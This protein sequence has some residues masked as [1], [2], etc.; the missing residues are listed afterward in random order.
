MS[1]DKP[2]AIAP[3]PGPQ[4]QFATCSA[5]IAIY[6]GAAGGGKSWA[7]LFEGFRGWNL[8]GYGGVIFRKSLTDITGPRGLWDLSQDLFG[9]CG[10][11]PR[12]SPQLDWTFPGGGRLAFSYLHHEGDELRHMGPEYAYVGFDEL[13]HIAEKAFWYL[14]TRNR[15]RCGIRPYMRATCNPDSDSWVRDLIDWWIG[16]DGLPIPERSG[17]LRYFVRENDD[18]FWY[19][20]PEEAK[21]DWPERE[22]MSLTF[23]A[24]KLTDNAIL[25]RDDPRY[26]E[27]LR[28]GSRVNRARLLDGNWN[29]R[30][31]AGNYFR[32]EWVEVVDEVP[33]SEI[34]FRVRAWD[35]A[36]TEPGPGRN[37]DWS[38]GVLLARLANGRLLIEDV[39]RLRARPGP[40][41]A[42][43]RQVA[44]EDGPKVRVG[45]W[46]DPGSAGK[47]LAAH[48]KKRLACSHVETVVA[49]KNKIAYAEPVSAAFD[50]ESAACEHPMVYDRSWTQPFLSVLEGFPEAPHD[51]DV[52]ALSLGHMLIGQVN[53]G[54]KAKSA[55]GGRFGG[56]RRRGLM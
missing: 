31:E 38:V 44:E 10:A 41:E 29:I 48:L 45:L 14:W 22:A 39:V 49:A 28:A 40:L 51:D 37:P 25:M 52:D 9:T 50:P 55:S 7:L 19:D 18:I 17:V 15:S 4:M 16:E 8:P 2:E 56:S 13:T 30:A 27:I 6:G 11:R 26:L 23:I 33:E 21:A 42:R 43:L 20:S 12:M 3:Q 32:R 47:H 36:A 35:L 5:D 24:A 34:V 53:R 1:D 46:Q 54:F